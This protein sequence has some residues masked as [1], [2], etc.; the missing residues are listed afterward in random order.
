MSTPRTPRSR[1]AQHKYLTFILG[2][3]HYGIPSLKVQEIIGVQDITPVPRMPPFVR[4]VIN[5]RGKVI[6]V[7][8]LRERFGQAHAADTKRTCIIV[9]QA[10][11][12]AGAPV[13]LGCVVDQVQE[14]VDIPPEQIEP[15]PTFGAAID[16]SFIQGVGKIAKRVVMLLDIDRVLSEQE[17]AATAAPAASGA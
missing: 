11:R 13:T 3:E 4:G 17:L 9:V 5:L 1:S 7:V 12:S 16:T 8:G 6:A 10:A 2:S 14:V 15:A